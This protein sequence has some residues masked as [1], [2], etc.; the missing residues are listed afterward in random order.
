MTLEECFQLVTYKRYR[1]NLLRLRVSRRL[2]F[3]HVRAASDFAFVL[4]S[5]RIDAPAEVELAR[6]LPLCGVGDNFVEQGVEAF[7][8]ENMRSQCLSTTSYSNH[9]FKMVVM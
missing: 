4:R 6:G 9:T 2:T 1:E 5:R 3:A 7:R 8:L